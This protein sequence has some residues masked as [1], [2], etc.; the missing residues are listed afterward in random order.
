MGRIAAGVILFN[1]DLM[2]LRE[3]IEAIHTQV[4]LLVLI[5]NHSDNLAEIVR[6]FSHFQNIVMIKNEQN[7][8]IAKALNQTLLYCQSKGYTWVLTLDQDS[9]CPPNL[10]IEYNKYIANPD[11]AILSPVIEDRNMRATPPEEHVPSSCEP[12]NRC[13][14]SATLTNV[15]IWNELGGF[16]ETMFIDLVDLEYCKRVQLNG[17]K[18]LRINTVKLLHEVGH[19]TQPRLLF[20]RVQVLNHSAFRKYYIARNTLYFAWKH[21]T[22]FSILLAYLR[23]LKLLALTMLYEQDKVTK[24]KAILRGVKSARKLSIGDT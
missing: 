8:G 19:I 3:N 9:V 18:I 4:D 17:Y 1:P 21:R 13:I 2:R 15:K 22:R 7:L 14:T 12:I 10:I 20:W 6:E 11:V 23:V 16:D 5:D 24:S